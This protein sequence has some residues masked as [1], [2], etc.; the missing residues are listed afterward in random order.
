MRK[1]PAHTSYTLCTVSS[2]ECI[3]AFKEAFGFDLDNNSVQAI[4]VSRTDF[5]FKEENRVK[6]FENLYK[7]CLNA[8]YK[9]VLLYAPT[10]RGDADKAYIPEKLDIKALKENFGS[11]WVL[12]VKRHGFVKKEWDIP[13]DCQDFAFDITE[14]M[15]IEDLLFTADMCITDYS[16]LIFEYSLFE[17]PMIFYA[18]DLDQFY[19]YRG[20]YYPYDY[21]FLPGPIVKTNEELINAIKQ[22]KADPTVM[23]DFRERFM[24]ACDGRSTERIADYIMSQNSEY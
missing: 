1:F 20:F 4:G 19:D 5:F 11:E 3:W 15:P 8:Q 2:K 17:R 23:S 13:E 21:S 6:A 14:H 24:G 7:N 10:Y 22:G 12:L 16:S 18:F 9:K